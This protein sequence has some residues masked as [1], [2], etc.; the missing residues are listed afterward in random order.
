[1]SSKFCPHNNPEETDIIPMVTISKGMQVK[2]R[3]VK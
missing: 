3:E 1:M 2:L